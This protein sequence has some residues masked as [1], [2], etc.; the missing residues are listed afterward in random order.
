MVEGARMVRDV[1]AVTS[2]STAAKNARLYDGWQSR[3]KALLDAAAEQIARA[4][5]R[6]KKQGAPGENPVEFMVVSGRRLLEEHLAGMT[7]SQVQEYCGA[8]ADLIAF[9]DR[10]ATD[11]LRKLLEIVTNAD[12]A[13][14]EREK[15]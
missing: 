6:L 3:H 8:Y 4:N 13:L 12:Q 5:V 1:C 10:E 7:P 14:S 2:P 11:S 9:K 15:T